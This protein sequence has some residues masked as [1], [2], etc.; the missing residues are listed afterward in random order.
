M[1][2]LTAGVTVSLQYSD[3]DTCALTVVPDVEVPSWGTEE[4]HTRSSGAGLCR[5]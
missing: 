3:P 5:H 1:S 4:L 2:K